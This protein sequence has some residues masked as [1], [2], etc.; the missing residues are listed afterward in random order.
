VPLTKV[1]W[2]RAFFPAAVPSRKQKEL[3]MN[4]AQFLNTTD[5]YPVCPP[6]P[7][8]LHDG[9]KDKVRVAV[10]GSFLGGYHVLKELLGDA[11]QHYVEIVGVA[12][13]DP[14][15]PFTHPQVRLWKY[16]HTRNDEILVPHFAAEQGIPVWTGR[17]KSEA[18]QDLFI[19]SWSPKLCLMAT[20]GQKI[21]RPIFTVPKFGFYNFHHSDI[22][23][24]SY[25]GPDPIA[26][27]IRD[28]KT[29]VVLTMHE[30]TD[31]IDGGC[32]IARSQRLPLPPDVNAIQLH[33]LTWPTMGPFIRH[34][35][36]TILERMVLIH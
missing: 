36:K 14:T 29:E 17:V 12:T 13:D 10:F 21:P 26:G 24:P 15:Q 25:A 35:V 20:Y 16:P 27:M 34:Q 6:F 7:F 30:V 11:L 31:V 1:R 19:R 3:F 2:V 28:K 33:R 8:T 18:F 5:I 32:F 4:G 22:T 9:D 23:W